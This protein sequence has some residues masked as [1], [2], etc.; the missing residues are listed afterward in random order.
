MDIR[1]V[2][3]L[4]P[5]PADQVSGIFVKKQAEALT[6]RGH[7]VTVISPVPYVPRAVAD[8]LN[9]PSSRDIPTTD[10]FGDVAVHYPRYWSLP[11]AE[12]LPLNAYSFRRTLRRHRDLFDSADVINAHV[13]LPDGFGAVPLAASLDLPLVTTVHGADLQH[14]VH[15]RLARRQLAV[16]F[17]NSDRVIVN[18]SK[19]K[20]LYASHFG[21]TDG[22][23]I[24]HNGINVENIR[25]QDP[26][27]RTDGRTR[28]ISVGSLVPEKGHEYTL[29]ALAEVD[30]EYELLLIGDGPQ[31]ESLEEL[32]SELGIAT[33]VRFMGQV[34]HDVVISNL[35]S[36]DIFVLPSYEEAFGIA[37]L[38]AMACG[39]PAIGCRGEGPAD[40]ISHNKTGVLVS[41][42]AVGELSRAMGEL[43]TNPV[44]RTQIARRA[45]QVA[46]CGFSW[47]R[48]AELVERIFEAVTQ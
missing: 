41:P 24:V 16:V 7:D 45:Q 39:L 17:S 11:R 29:R 44:R 36:S 25:R 18:S 4:F 3:H 46:L 30:F 40:Y 26:A 20:R 42:H 27:P 5:S 34:D 1:V 38:E 2:S 33:A 6:R 37:Y 21:A 28:I 15:R 9:R 22:V 19:L 13:A 12:T 48:N 23:E 43:A 47:D 10:S 32:A 35:K 31:R 8:A 14:S